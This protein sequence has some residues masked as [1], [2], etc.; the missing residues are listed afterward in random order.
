MEPQE[1]PNGLGP[2]P[3]ML[4]DAEEM[5]FANVLNLGEGKGWSFRAIADPE[6]D[7]YIV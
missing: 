5:G 2:G 4:P 7:P 1:L 6:V 3:P